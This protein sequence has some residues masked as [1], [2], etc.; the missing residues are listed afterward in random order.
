MIASRHGDII[1]EELE[2]DEGEN[3]FSN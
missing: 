2:R 1:G 3:G